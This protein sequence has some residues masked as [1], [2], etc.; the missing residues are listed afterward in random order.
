MFDIIRLVQL[1]FLASC[2]YHVT[3]CLATCSQCVIPCL[4]T[5]PDTQTAALSA[6]TALATSTSAS[7]IVVPNNMGRLRS[8]LRPTLLHI[9]AGTLSIASNSSHVSSSSP[10]STSSSQS[11]TL[12]PST[13][14]PDYY[15]LLHSDPSTPLSSIKSTYY[16]LAL[17]YH[18]DRTSHYSADVKDWSD[19]R[20]RLLSTAWRT[21]SDPIK[22]QQ[23]DVQ[24]SLNAVGDS[25]RMQ[26]W[27]R[28]HR[29]PEELMPPPEEMSEA[30]KRG[31]GAT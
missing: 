7:L 1:R 5:L 31:A 29:P 8:T 9:R 15:A 17:H 21:L 6:R 27:L 23:Y 30:G 24:R 16:R 22:R 18:P 20:F 25:H 4:A 26:H 10:F 19:R 14:L 2:R 28:V 3:V 13:P 12:L 11:S